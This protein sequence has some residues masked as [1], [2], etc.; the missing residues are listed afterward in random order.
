MART[1]W[2]PGAPALAGAARAVDAVV[3]QGESVD[4]ALAAAEGT[5]ERAAIRAISLGSLRWYLR[6]APAVGVLLSRPRDVEPSVHALLVC[7]AH[8]I[9]YSRN[10]PEASVHAAVDAMRLLGKA[11]AAVWRT[12]CCGA[13]RPNVAPSSSASRWIRW[14]AP[15][16]PPG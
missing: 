13:S 10:A 8:Q 12:R 1:P 6:L 2:A 14:Y 3:S 11:P 16:I 15:P 5:P 7:A 9:E 4:A